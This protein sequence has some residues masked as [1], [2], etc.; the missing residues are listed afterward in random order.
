[1]NSYRIIGEHDIFGYSRLNFEKE[2]SLLY[3]FMTIPLS[4]HLKNQFSYFIA[5][6]G[7]YDYFDDNR[8]DSS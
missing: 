1:M 3:D 4:H 7:D 2:L 5:D 6:S 8:W